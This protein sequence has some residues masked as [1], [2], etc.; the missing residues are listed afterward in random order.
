MKKIKNKKQLQEEKKRIKIRKTELE[1]KMQSQW[2]GLKD[3]LRPVNIAKDTFS[4]FLDKKAVENLADESIL[5]ST[6]NYG[7]SLMAKKFTDKAGEK[8]K[9]FFKKNG[10]E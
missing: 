7:I 10:K 1:K 6:L 3:S 4:S 2:N 5:K 8:F 9:W